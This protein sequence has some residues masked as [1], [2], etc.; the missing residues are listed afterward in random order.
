MELEIDLKPGVFRP[1]DHK[2]NGGRRRVTARFIAESQQVK[3]MLET[4]LNM[5]RQNLESRDYEWTVLKL[6]YSLTMV[7]YLTASESSCQYLWEEGQFAEGRQRDG[8]YEGKQYT[9]GYEEM[10][11]AVTKGVADY[12]YNENGSLN[13]LI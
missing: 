5:L 7:V 1:A 8:P 12:G 10:D 13:F 11:P 2:G 3:Q 9:G 6:V 4:N